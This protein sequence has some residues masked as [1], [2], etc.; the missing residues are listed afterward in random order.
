MTALR[1]YARQHLHTCGTENIQ[2]IS[3]SLYLFLTICKP[4][5]QN[6]VTNQSRKQEGPLPIGALRDCA[7]IAVAGRDVEKNANKTGNLL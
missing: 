3:C 6:R 4:K 5:A 7:Q 2:L 1:D